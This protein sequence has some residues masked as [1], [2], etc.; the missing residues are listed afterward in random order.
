MSAHDNR[1]LPAGLL[2]LI[3]LIWGWTFVIVKDAVALYGVVP[4]LAVRFLIGALCLAPLGLRRGAGPTFGLGAAIGLVMGAAFLLQTLGLATS[5]ASN[6]GLITGLFVVFAPLTNRLLFGVRLSTGCWIG[7]GLSLVGL[8]LLTGAGGEAMRR[9]DL[10]TL[11]CA[12]LFGLH[13]ALLDRHARGRNPLALATGQV[14]AAAVLFTLVWLIQGPVAWP[15]R[16]VWP[17][18]LLTGVLASAAAYLVQ[19]YAQQRLRAEQTALIMLAEPLFAVLF[20][21]WLH[22]DRF[23]GAQLAGGLLMGAAMLGTEWVAHRPAAQAAG[24]AARARSSD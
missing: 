11:G 8:A 13:V 3:V 22:G 16:A 4:F 14:A 19:T 24:Y 5:S 21:V 10:L 17:A 23:T 6:T 1:L 12:A 18:L 7:I 2:L 20:G 9:G 15:P